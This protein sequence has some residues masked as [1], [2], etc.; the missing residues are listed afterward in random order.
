MRG[1]EAIDGIYERT[2]PVWSGPGAPGRYFDLLHNLVTPRHQAALQA[3]RA[4]LRVDD[5]EPAPHH[6]DPDGRVL[7]GLRRRSCPN[8]PLFV[9][10]GLLAWNLFSL[11]STQGLAS[12]VDSGALIRKV[13]VPKEMFPLAAVAANLVNFLFSLVPLAARDAGHAGAD[14]LG[15]SLGAGRRRPDR[16]LHARRR[17]R[18]RDLERLLPRRPLL[19]RS[20]PCW[21]GSTERRSSTRS[22]SLSPRARAVLQWN[23]MYVLVDVFRTPIY[24]GIAAGPGRRHRRTSRRSAWPLS[25]GGSSAATR[26]ASWTSSDHRR[27]PTIRRRPHRRRAA[28]AVRYDLQLERVI[29]VR[30]YA[31]R[32]LRGERF[33]SQTMWPIRERVVH[34]PGGRELRHRRPERGRQEH[35]PQGDRRHRPADARARRGARAAVAAPR[36]RRRLRHGAHRPREHPAL[37]DAARAP[38]EASAGARRRDRR[39]RRAHAVHRRPAQELLVGHGGAPRASRSRPTP[40]PTS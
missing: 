2:P 38:A 33:P 25:A 10:I 14:H 19:L 9:I 31:I 8:Y 12:V 24:A 6:G 15:D 11:G 37:R 27:R 18:A 5:A 17:A 13:A 30:E 36:A 3:L 7:G 32:R 23:P 16:A 39:L 29:S 35:A 1:A 34:R 21:R 40:I 4:R 26:R 28:L 20:R 22:T